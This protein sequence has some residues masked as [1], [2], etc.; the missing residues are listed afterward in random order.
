[1]NY[2]YE[3]DYLTKAQQLD[4]LY[5]EKKSKLRMTLANKKMNET[6][7]SKKRTETNQRKLRI[8]SQNTRN[9]EL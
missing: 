3:R 4:S 1:M 5:Q 8:I 2:Q 6:L 9:Q 7:A